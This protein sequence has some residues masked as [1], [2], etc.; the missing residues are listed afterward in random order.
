MRKP[1]TPFDWYWRAADGRLF[2]SARCALVT[3]LDAS[4]RAWSDGGYEPTVWP[5]DVAGMQT[6]V[7]LQEVLSPYGLTGPA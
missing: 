4:Y 1:Y 7:A 5:K 3:D 2:S 6:S